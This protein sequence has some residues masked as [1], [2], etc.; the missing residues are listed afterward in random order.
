MIDTA[1]RERVEAQVDISC[2][3]CADRLVVS[4]YDPLKGQM[5]RDFMHRHHG[6]QPLIRIA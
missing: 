1:L 4:S 2:E 6:H 3:T 5:V